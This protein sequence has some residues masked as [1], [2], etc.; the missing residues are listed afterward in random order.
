L[1]LSD[2]SHAS[3]SGKIQELLKGETRLANDAFQ[4][5]RGQVLVVHG[6]RD[7]KVRPAT[8]KQA[9][10]AASLVMDVKPRAFEDAKNLLGFEHR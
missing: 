8:V 7:A 3:G 5:F 2:A 6:D 4:G 1:D 9:G 10:M